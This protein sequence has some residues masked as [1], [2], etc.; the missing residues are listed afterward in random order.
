MPKNP[1]NIAL[2]FF[3]RSARKEGIYKQFTSGY[4][5]QKDTQIA[6]ALIQHTHQQIADSGLPCFVYNEENQEGTSFGERFTNAFKSIFEQGFDYVISVGNDTPALKTAHLIDAARQLKSGTSDIVLGPAADGG[7]WLMGYSR[8]AFEGSSFLQLPWNSAGLLEAILGE[9][10]RLFSI[11]LLETLGDIDDAA[12][13]RSFIRAFYVDRS[14]FNL[15]QVLRSVISANTIFFVN[16]N[17]SY[18]S[19]CIFKIYLRRAPPLR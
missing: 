10:E 1:G 15:V 5:S 9:T 14:L 12:S 6:K 17:R 2:L 8:D 3:S 7:T 11:S 4:D 13:L 18:I 16:L 19:G